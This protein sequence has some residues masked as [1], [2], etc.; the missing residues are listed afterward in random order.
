MNFIVSN[1][2]KYGKNSS[3]HN[4]NTTNEHCF[5]RQSANLSCFRKSAF[6]AG[7]IIVNI[8]YII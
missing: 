3:I 4:M 5:H 6:Y 8:Y 1:Q 7:I 2:E